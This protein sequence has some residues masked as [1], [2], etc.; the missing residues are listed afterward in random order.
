MYISDEFRTNHLSLKPG[1]SIVQIIYKN[2]EVRIYDK[3]K[4]PKAYI[5]K[6]PKEDIQS[7][8]LDGKEIFLNI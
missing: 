8:S 2:G 6:L 1:G 7:I 4:Y 3:I 5:E